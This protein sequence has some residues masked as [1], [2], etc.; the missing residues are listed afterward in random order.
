MAKKIS[1]NK[2]SMKTP[3]LLIIQIMLKYLSDVPFERRTP[4]SIIVGLNY[5]RF[6]RY[7]KLLEAM[8]WIRPVK[9]KKYNTTALKITAT[10]KKF[11]K[12]LEIYTR[13][14]ENGS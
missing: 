10:G 1:Y 4:L 9:M 13:N 11:L 6:M 12:K 8:E 7:V 3:S 14:A 5:S 2:S